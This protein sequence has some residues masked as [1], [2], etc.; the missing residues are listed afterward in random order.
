V[1]DNT[2]NARKL[3]QEA[4]RAIPGDFALREVRFHVNQAI[5][6]LEK[7]EE[8][9]ASKA[10]AAQDKKTFAQNWTEML[11]G[12]LTNPNSPGRTLDII[13]QMIAEENRKLEEILKK[14]EAEAKNPQ[15]KRDEDEET[16]FD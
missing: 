5:Q 3:L 4:M 11:K 2:L 8:K 1:K 6:K 7:V 13:N 12:G 14:R 15:Q 10:Q 9:R 16:L